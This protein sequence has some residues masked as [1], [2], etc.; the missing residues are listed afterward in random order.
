MKR[1][2]QKDHEGM[3]LEKKRKGKRRKQHTLGL[4]TEDSVK[5]GVTFI[6]L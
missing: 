3:R 1:M 4:E 2:R 6:G 5:I